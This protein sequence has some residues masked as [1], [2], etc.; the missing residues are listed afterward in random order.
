[1]H[2]QDRSYISDPIAQNKKQRGGLSERIFQSMA[3]L[4]ILCSIS[5]ARLARIGVGFGRASFLR[6]FW[7]GGCF[8]LRSR[9]VAIFVSKRST[10]LGVM[11]ATLRFFSFGRSHLFDIQAVAEAQRV[12]SP[13]ELAFIVHPMG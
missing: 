12:R 9:P 10:W 6:R 7:M 1:M 5:P 2:I 3:R 13:A 11:S 8:E 4:K